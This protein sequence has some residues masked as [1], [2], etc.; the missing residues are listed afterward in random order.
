[1]KTHANI[2]DTILNT[3]T[4]GAKTASVDLG[5]SFMDAETRG[6][7]RGTGAWNNKRS[8]L[9]VDG[10]LGEAV[11]KVAATTPRSMKFASVADATAFAASIK[12]RAGRENG[13]TFK[14]ARAALHRLNQLQSRTAAQMQ[15]DGA[16]THEGYL[17]ASRFPVIAKRIAA[18]I[19]FLATLRSKLPVPKTASADALKDRSLSDAEAANTVKNWLNSGATP[20][21]VAE[22]IEKSAELQGFS[23]SIAADTLKQ[24]AGVL[25]YAYLEPN[26]YM[27]DCSSTAER[28]KLKMG[29][30][31]AKSVMKIKACTGCQ[32]F[33]KDAAGAAS[34]SIYSLPIV[35]SK[36]ELMPII[37]N[38]VGNAKNKQ[39]RL[40]QLANRDDAHVEPKVA[41]GTSAVASRA[42]AHA[43]VP[44]L[45][46]A[47]KVSKSFTAAD[48]LRLHNA[49]GKLQDIYGQGERTVGSKQASVAVKGFLSGLKGSQTKLALTQIDCTK[50]GGKLSSSNGIYGASKCATC[51]YRKVA[52]CGLTG[53]T[54]IKFPG[55]DSS[56]SN[57]RIASG[58]PFDGMAVIEEFD[59]LTPQLPSDIE[60]FE[61]LADVDLTEF[62]KV[63]I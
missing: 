27:N 58:A 21:S 10:E 34:C 59:M 44:S 43:R 60:M 35:A 38:L 57:H 24:N 48:V 12:P 19:R 49:G 20:K 51:T 6:V 29:G 1:M 54:L 40:I 9:A 8:S 53:G 61:P 63:D 28:M 33:R 5:D 16:M 47:A 4:G 14:A 42:V 22:K 31:R 13:T 62:S 46:P 50:L 23:N 7:S 37:N 26:H 17:D 41:S 56:S 25:G 32:H 45:Q 39:A 55:M 15:R 18:D 3:P 36:N 2:I 52:H 11:S 30:V